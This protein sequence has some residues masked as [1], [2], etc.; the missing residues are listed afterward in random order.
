M[1]ILD[2]AVPAKKYANVLIPGIIPRFD[3]LNQK[4]SEISKILRNECK[5]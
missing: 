1:G 5:K 2:L 3:K 4:A